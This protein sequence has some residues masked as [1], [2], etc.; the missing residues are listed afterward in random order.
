[1]VSLPG[2]ASGSPPRQPGRPVPFSC[3]PHGLALKWRCRSLRNYFG[4]LA[5]ATPAPLDIEAAAR[6]ELD[7][8]QARRE[9]VAPQTYG[10]MIAQVSAL[11]YGRKSEKLR[12]AGVLRA[13]AIAFRNARDGA[14]TDADWSAIEMRLTEAYEILKREVL[15]GRPGT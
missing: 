10:A 11:L 3:R 12:E 8:W 9:A 7:W 15:N 14:I 2:I 6:A 1:M 4:L 5:C 13:E